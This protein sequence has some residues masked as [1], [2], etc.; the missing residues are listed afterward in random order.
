MSSEWQPVTRSGLSVALL[1]VDG[2]D[3]EALDDEALLPPEEKAR[4]RRFRGEELAR[5][6]RRA[7]AALRILLAREMGCAPAAVPILAAA[8]TK[9]RLPDSGLHFNLS[10]SQNLAAIVIARGREVGIDVEV[11]VRD[12]G[13]VCALAERAFHPCEAA[14]LRALPERGRQEAFLRLWTVREALLKAMGTGLAAPRE[15]IDASPVLA[16]VQWLQWGGWSVTTAPAP[17]GCYVALAAAGTGWGYRLV[18]PLFER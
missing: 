10:H 15:M 18:S 4:A 13:D 7:H 12:L 3:C 16:G 6:F 1:D 17:A 11:R 14:A 5:R 8:G 2:A 9:P